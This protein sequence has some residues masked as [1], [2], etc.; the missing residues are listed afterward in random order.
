MKANEQ[1]ILNKIES[2]KKQLNEITEMRLGSL[3]QQFNVCGNPTCRCKANPPQKHGPYYQVSFTRK[4]KSSSRFVK[5]SDL[6]LVQ[7]QIDDYKRFRE[8]ID[9]WIDLGVELADIHLEKHRKMNMQI[10]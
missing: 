10:E 8:L 5:Q 3:S 7:R 9:E 1:K 4:G 2:V 6:Q